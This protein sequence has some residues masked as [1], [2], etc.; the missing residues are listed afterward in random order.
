MEDK[1]V[2]MERSKPIDV[3][4]IELGDGKIGISVGHF[5][6]GS[7]ALCFQ[8]LNKVHPVGDIVTSKGEIREIVFDRDTFFIEFKNEESISVLERQLLVVRQLLTKV[9][10]PQQIADNL[11]PI[12]CLGGDDCDGDL[13]A[14]PHEPGCPMYK[15]VVDEG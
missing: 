4:K 9:A 8:A 3:R 2:A 12:S 6:E 10:T 14:E 5:N 15:E 1:K 7:M 13:I 11:G